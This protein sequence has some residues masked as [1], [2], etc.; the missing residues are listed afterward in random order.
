MGFP[1]SWAVPWLQSPLPLQLWV[2]TF[3]SDASE[4][5]TL[6]LAQA[7]CGCECICL[8]VNANIPAVCL[9]ALLPG[10]IP[11]TCPQP[12]D[13]AGRG[14][15]SVTCRAGVQPL[16]FISALLGS[17]LGRAG[18]VVLEKRVGRGRFITYPLCQVKG[19]DSHLGCVV[20]RDRKRRSHHPM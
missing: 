14:C 20:F 17:G 3:P 15:L 12:W 5:I 6:S 13:L 11:K 19:W 8:C 7:P 18:V 4:D 1:S 9:H 2:G 16:G 10:L